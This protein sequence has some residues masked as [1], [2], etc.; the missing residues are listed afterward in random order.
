M[1]AGESIGFVGAGLMGRGMARNLLRAGHL[2]HALRPPPTRRAGR[3]CWRW[4]PS[5]PANSVRRAAQQVIILCVDNAQTVSNVVDNLSPALRAG[6]LLIDAT[7]SDPAITREV[8][9]KLH[10][11]GV[12]ADAPVTG[13]PQQAAAGTLGALA[14]L[15][16][17][18]S[19]P[20]IRKSLRAMQRRC[21]A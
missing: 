8:A 17:E 11:R 1:N 15:H 20:R 12:S 16:F 18:S 21:N 7:T 6:Q 4:A 5:R 3:R 10:R 9:A 2:G 19:F 14:G 13:G